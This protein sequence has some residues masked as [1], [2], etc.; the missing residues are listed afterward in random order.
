MVIVQ[1]EHKFYVRILKTIILLALLLVSREKVLAQEITGIISRV[2]ETTHLEFRGRKNWQYENPQK[3]NGKIIINLPPFNDATLVQ[4]QSWSCPLIKE[5]K[6]NKSAPDNQYQMIISL[7][8]DDVESFDYLTEDPSNLIF[9]FYQQPDKKAAVVTPAAAEKVTEAPMPIKRNKI[10]SKISKL[11]EKISSQPEEYK[12][13]DRKP[14][15]TETLQVV[16]P[17]D[18]EIKE[19]VGRG[20]FDGGD[21]NYDRF[22]AKDYQINED[23]I[24]ASQ[25]NI[26][27]KFPILTKKLSRFSE[28]MKVTPEYEIKVDGTEESKVASLILALY[29]KNRLGTLFET[30]QYFDKKFP[31]SKYDEIVKNIKAEAYIKV[32]ERDKNKNDY[33]SF[34]S[35]YRYLVE[36]Y[37]DSALAERNTLLLAYSSLEHGDGAETLRDMQRYLDKYPNSEERD[38]VL[39]AIGESYFLLNKP[40]DA[41]Q[42]YEEL[43]K[44]PVDK[45]YGVD[46]AYRIGDIHMGKFAYKA[47]LESYEN[48]Q[49]KYPQFISEFPNAQ[50]NIAEAQ[51]WLKQYKESLNSYIAFLQS[52][53]SSRHGGFAQTRIGELLEILGADQKQIMGA[54]IEGYFRFP[55]S[56]GSEVARIRILSRTLKGMS[57]REKKRALEEMDEITKKSSLPDMAEFTI[58]I[59]ADGLSSRKEYNPALNLLVSYYQDNPTTANLNVFKGRILRNISDVLFEQTNSGR[60]IEALNFYGKYSTS[61][62]KNTDRID[63]P[64]LQGV[65]YEQAG[66]A[67]QA[68]KIYENTALRLSQIAGKKEEGERRVYENLP[69]M[70]QVNLRLAAVALQDKKYQDSYKY[71]SSISTH[72][73]KLSQKEEIERVQIGAV[74]SEQM[75]DIKN[76]ISYLEKLVASNESNTEAVVRPQLDLAR[77]YL[78]QNQLADADKALLAVESSHSDSSNLKDDE[79]AKALELRAELHY[80]SGQKLAAVET[81]IKLLDAY[82]AKFPLSSIRYRAGKILFDEGDLRGAEKVWS[83]LGGGDGEFYKKLSMEKLSQAEWQDTYKKYIERIPAAQDL[84]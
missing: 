20:V 52:F 26:Y 60:Y 63:A 80:R 76:A 5:I 58:L 8:S 78:T 32:Y 11:P 34:R 71:I 73:N 22:R 39:L 24:I 44:N 33:E 68:R 67:E 18:A 82:E 64:Y 3:E 37:P 36:T 43:S 30:F 1:D 19:Q 45:V 13:L 66:V 14:A 9:D 7:N 62:L 50:Y 61:W 12:K 28:L 40:G 54:Y 72:K 57:E 38:R 65:A 81:Y 25:Q 6:I 59:K 15:G 42:T 47:A 10:K 29:K 49:K 75:G 48:V 74:V 17:P 77:L 41:I 79:W 4:L 69:L 23:A 21:P 2:G 31:N 51:F 55:E 84:K 70:D 56:Q 35:L 46:A 27:I 83:N 53:P 16:K